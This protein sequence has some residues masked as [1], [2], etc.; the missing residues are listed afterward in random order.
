MTSKVKFYMNTNWDY[1]T[2]NKKKKKK[3]MPKGLTTWQRE[4]WR[5]QN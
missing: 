4:I 2:Y 1:L 3:K 5:E